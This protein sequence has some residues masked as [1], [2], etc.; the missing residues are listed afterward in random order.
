MAIEKDIPISMLKRPML[1]TLIK[2]NNIKGCLHLNKDKMMEKLIEKGILQQINRPLFIRIRMGN[3]EICDKIDNEINNI[4]ECPRNNGKT[5]TITDLET[6]E[7]FIFDSLHNAGKK[8]DKP[9]S[10]IQS[11]GGKSIE[12]QNKRYEIMIK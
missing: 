5:V 3:N 10:Y 4:R 7:K 1:K 11:Y 6:Q 8:F 2:D 9:G 12:F